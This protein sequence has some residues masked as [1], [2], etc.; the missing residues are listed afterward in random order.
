MPALRRISRDFL[1]VGGPTLG[2][3]PARGLLTLTA[4]QFTGGRSPAVALFEAGEIGR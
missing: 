1:A 4:D 3:G 2:A